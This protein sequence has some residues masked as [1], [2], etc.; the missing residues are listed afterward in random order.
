MAPPTWKGPPAEVITTSNLLYTSLLMSL[1]AAFVAMLG[2]EWLNRYL[3]HTGGSAAER[4]GDRQ[5]KFDGLKKWPFHLFLRSLPIML[6]IALLLLACS[7]S[8]YMLSVNTS[9]GHMVISLTALGVLFYIGIV[10]VGTSSYE[11]PFQTHASIALR[12]L[13]DS[14]IA[15]KLL[16]NLSPLNIISLIYIIWIKL[17]ESLS[18]PSS[19]SLIYAAQMDGCQ[20]LIS[21]FHH[22]CDTVGHPSSWDISLSHIKSII[23][24][25]ATRVGHQVIILLLQIDQEFRNMKRG[26]VQG[27]QRSRNR[28]LLPTYVTQTHNQPLI[29]KNNTWL[30]LH[31]W[32][33]ERTQ[34]QN[35]DTARCV[36]WTLWNITDPEA[37]SSAIHL[38]GTIRWFDGDSSLDLPFDVVVS[39]F[40]AC[41]DS[42]KELYPGMRDWAYYSAR[43]I[44]QINARARAQSHEHA[45]KYCIPAIPSNSIQYADPD[46]HHIIH[47]LELN[48]GMGRPILDFPRG[49]TNTHAHML[50]MSS[51][52]V[53][54][55]HV[56]LNPILKSYWSYLSIANTNHKPMII[57]TLLVWYMLLGGHVEEEA[58]W[59]D[60]TL[61]AVFPSSF[62]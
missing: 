30:Q 53:E 16:A 9:V 13:R 29:P 39:I 42:T 46:L 45:L 35:R 20:W 61:Y 10:I 12:Y 18:L 31:V 14:G 52:F 6:Q 8:R 38:A 41:F 1:F 62:L 49:G 15:W 48:S 17:S 32:N 54:L 57:N 2:K 33:L 5:R 56:G 44:L 37:I 47:M 40:E 11:C 21:I 19:A 26:L 25:T 3:R 24:N 36:S 60:N 28:W 27:V 50:W 55:T 4:Y 58:F 7:L 22:I 23:S 34:R 59:A 43:A 51:L